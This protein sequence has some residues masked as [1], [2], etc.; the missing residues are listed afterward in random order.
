MT[1]MPSVSVIIPTYN[2]AHLVTRAVR[3]ALNELTDDDE[4][5]V[6][7][8]GSTDDTEQVLKPYRERIR[9]VKIP[10]SGAGRA[11]NVGL[12]EAGK[13]LVAFLDS[14]DEWMPGK[15]ELHRRF[16]A[17]RPDVLLS[18]TDFAITTLDG[19]EVRHYLQHWHQDPRD[20]DAILGEGALFSTLATLPPGCP[21]FRVH[22]GNLYVPM[23]RA[24]YIS[25]ITI[26][27]QREKAGGD[28]YF[29]EDL[30]LYEDWLCFGRLCRK[31]LAAY[32]DIETAWQHAH[33]GRRLSGADRLCAAETRLTMLR[34]L[35]G[36]DPD[37]V[38]QHGEL[39]N[40]VIEEQN[41]RKAAALISLGRTSEARG[42]LRKLRRAP[43]SYRL[44]AAMPGSIARGAVSIRR[45]IR[46]LLKISEDTNTIRSL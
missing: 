21:D 34:R 27:V 35:W 10:N 1:T 11:R 37:F 19:K 24:P 41:R 18:F 8:D 29:E 3:S 31:G 12:M 25:T 16:H 6:V 2:R 15:L 42:V 5:I 32:F 17:A 45:I 20:W 46:S 22:V 14:D 28:L 38:K 33:H 36:S 9:Y 43:L 44:L 39:L 26:V 7:D 23:A 40:E 13:D 30:L 4:I